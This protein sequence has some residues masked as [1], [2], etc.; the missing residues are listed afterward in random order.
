MADTVANIV[1]GAGEIKNLYTE[2]GFTVGD[3]LVVEMLGTGLAKL[4]A[5][6]TLA[7]EPTNTTGYSE[8]VPGESYVNQTDDTGAFIW[9]RQGCTVQV[10]KA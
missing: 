8:L 9:S 1:V 5:G 4:Y 6:T 3:Q 7:V 10:R 2:T